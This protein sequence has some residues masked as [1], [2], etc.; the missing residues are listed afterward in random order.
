M[1]E[2]EGHPICENCGI[3]SGIH[4]LEE[5]EEYLSRNPKNNIGSG[6]ILHKKI[7]E[8]VGKQETR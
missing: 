4:V 7:Q 6:S 8:I 2:N 1:I 5:C 3:W